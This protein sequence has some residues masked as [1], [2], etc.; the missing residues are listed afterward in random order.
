M[1]TDRAMAASRLPMIM[2]IKSVLQLTEQHVP[3]EDLP[4]KKRE[5]SI[6]L[7]PNLSRSTPILQTEMW[8]KP[9]RWTISSFIGK[10]RICSKGRSSSVVLGKSIVR[11]VEEF[12]V[13]DRWLF[14]VLQFCW[15]ILDCMMSFFESLFP[16]ANSSN[17]W[18]SMHRNCL[19]FFPFLH[20]R[21]IR[22]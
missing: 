21:S 19:F 5:I 8:D 22:S 10:K 6:L 1:S 4:R 2:P 15:R 20:F 17:E 3:T 13:P 18:I 9:L 14:P 11:I 16:S 12:D 7:S